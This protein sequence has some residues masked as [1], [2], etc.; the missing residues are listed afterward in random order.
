MK[1]NKFW[2]K[3]NTD[4]NSTE[5]KNV[6][7]KGPFEY[8]HHLMPERCDSRIAIPLSSLKMSILEA[9]QHGEEPGEITAIDTKKGKLI[10]VE[11]NPSDNVYV[12]IPKGYVPKEIAYALDD[13]GNLGTIIRDP[14]SFTCEL[15][16]LELSQ[17]T[18]SESDND[19]D[20]DAVEKVSNRKLADDIDKMKKDGTNKS[21]STY[22]VY[23]IKLGTFISSITADI[24]RCGTLCE[25]KDLA[26]IGSYLTI[27]HEK[28]NKELSRFWETS[29][30]S[31]NSYF[32]LPNKDKKDGYS[33]ELGL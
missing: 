11:I 25:N 9:L 26:N 24:V 4:P 1:M 32:V 7:L 8:K 14:E 2:K 16:D 30:L 19:S 33:I 13:M 21:S 5:A 29:E 17:L 6:K 10:T 3:V 28:T 27:V 12:I 31:N 20:N 18:D 22:K 15:A 23:K